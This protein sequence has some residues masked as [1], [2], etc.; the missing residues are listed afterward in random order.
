MMMFVGAVFL[1]QGINDQ[2]DTAKT[3]GKN[4]SRKQWDASS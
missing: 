3:Q 2:A 4:K 1:V